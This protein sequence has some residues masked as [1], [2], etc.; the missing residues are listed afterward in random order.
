M[1][2]YRM[3]LLIGFLIVAYFLCN[4]FFKIDIVKYNYD[5][6]YNIVEL[7]DELLKVSSKNKYGILANT[8]EVLL[9][10]E[11]DE[12]NFDQD[13]RVIARKKDKYGV[14]ILK[15]EV[16]LDFIY[17]NI[18][19]VNSKYYKVKKGNSIFLIDKK[20]RKDI[21]LEEVLDI[22]YFNKNYFIIKKGSIEVFDENLNKKEI[23]LGD[24][25]YPISEKIFLLGDK[26]NYYLISREKK[27][28]Y[29]ENIEQI[30]DEYLVINEGNKRSIKKIGEEQ[31][32]IMGY[33]T[34]YMNEK[35]SII[36]QKNGKYGVIDINNK[37]LIPYHYDKIS[38]LYKGYYAVELNFKCGLID[39]NGK[40]VL[41]L[42]YE[43]ITN[44]NQYFAMIYTNK[45]LEVVFLKE[46]N[47]VLSYLDEA[48]FLGDDKILVQKENSI[49]IYNHTG[50]KILALKLDEI[51]EIKENYIITKTS[52]IEF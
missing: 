34:I 12:L 31:S 10:L 29:S 8:G 1:K 42:E 47:F 50:E 28:K 39:K 4:K 43:A 15:N 2:K 44:F 38:P 27:I 30:Y 19:S 7:N 25:V 40:V 11:F 13:K 33:D 45:G 18:E 52:I 17:D 9:P 14:M 48:N 37:I 5:K 23:Y 41:P 49:E 35:D 16:Y 32:L 24:N 22:K 20:D 51:K 36:V 21:I 6:N 46:K 26:E 3:I